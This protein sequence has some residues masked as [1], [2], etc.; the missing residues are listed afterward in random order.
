MGYKIVY[1]K[2][3]KGNWHSARM[4]VIALFA[5]LLLFCVHMKNPQLVE[6]LREWLIPEAVE[7]FAQMLQGGDGLGETIV[8]FCQ[9]LING[10]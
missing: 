8:T 6:S 9:E 7:L 1:G 10:Q 2:R 5:F 3:K 4:L